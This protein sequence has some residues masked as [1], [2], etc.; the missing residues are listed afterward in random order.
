[1][2]IRPVFR[3][4]VAGLDERDVRLIE[5]V[6]KHSQY[7][8]FDFQ[9]LP[10]PDPL[11]TDILIANPVT[12]SGLD[13][14]SALRA[15]SRDI[16]AVNALPRGTQAAA[17]HAITIDRL[18]LQLLPTLNRVVEIEGLEG[19]LAEDAEPAESAETGNAAEPGD[20][21][22]KARAAEKAG[23]AENAKAAE[24]SEP[25]DR[26]DPGTADI[27]ALTDRLSPPA[28]TGSAVRAVAVSAGVTAAPAPALSPTPPNRGPHAG[29]RT[30]PWLDPADPGQPAAERLLASGSQA[31][32]PRLRRG[33]SRFSS[34]QA[35]RAGSA[36]AMTKA[37]T[38]AAPAGEPPLPPRSSDV[39]P[40]GPLRAAR[41]ATGAGLPRARRAPVDAAPD[42]DA[43]STIWSDA[44]LPGI[45]T[46]ATRIAIPGDDEGAPGAPSTVD[47]FATLDLD[48]L[49]AAGEAAH[50]NEGGDGSGRGAAPASTA[51]ATPVTGGAAASGPVTERA[52]RRLLDELA[53]P[54][55]DP[56]P[57]VA[58]GPGPGTAARPR[59]V[60]DPGPQRGNHAYL[61][62][63]LV[64]DPSLAAQQ[65][66]VRALQTDGVSLH[67]VASASA[68]LQHAAERQFDL[69][70]T[71]Y[72][73]ADV[74]GFHL[75]KALRQRAGYRSTPVLLLRS[76]SG[77]LDAARARLRGDVLLLNKPLTKVELQAVVAD[78]LRRS[79][80]L[81]DLET[82]YSD[83]DLQA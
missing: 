53:V 2:S 77:L 71:E 12:P 18:T 24:V 45:P 17:R 56:P 21:G 74:S 13:A 73:L 42:R 27:A 14:L 47:V 54:D 11:Q 60:P 25:P 37:V 61:L 43:A 44:G 32:S 41:P 79:L 20:A 5:I 46:V 8:R 69:V 75:I 19:Q 82:L 59:L 80:V 15:L 29:G 4:A 23:A 83:G 40:A 10:Q 3:V 1:M 81:D 57:V 62:Q 26:H 31:V 50:L 65:Q 28:V 7:N 68:A 63:I 52:S 67:C 22:E 38:T 30:E 36:S 64:A 49:F 39:N 66:L 48:A 6:F 9:L 35:A 51:S 70:I 33:A 55:I 78:A 76:R 72:S 58:P 16:P 34:G